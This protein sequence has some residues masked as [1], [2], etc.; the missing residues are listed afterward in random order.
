MVRSILET[1]LPTLSTQLLIFSIVK[2]FKN[3]EDWP[4]T[5][6]FIRAIQICAAAG[7]TLMNMSL[8]RDSFSQTETSSAITRIFNQGVLL[9]A[10]AGSDG[11]SVKNYPASYASRMSV[12]VVDRN[13][14][15]GLYSQFNSQVSI[16]AP[17]V[18]A[19]AIHQ[20]CRHY[21]Q[22]SYPVASLL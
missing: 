10:A 14:N 6:D 2:V 16:A 18:G 19:V 12:A 3:G 9:V 20:H 5:S 17:G 1:T 7:A 4:W 13:N 8:G 15:C 22:V 21:N 11:N